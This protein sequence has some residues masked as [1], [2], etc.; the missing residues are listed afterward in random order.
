VGSN[1][2]RHPW[3]GCGSRQA[4]AKRPRTVR[5]ASAGARLPNTKRSLRPQ[6]LRQGEE[7]ASTNALGRSCLYNR[8]RNKQKRGG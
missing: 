1:V 4:S 5:E 3:R 6:L 8:E 7:L 2:R